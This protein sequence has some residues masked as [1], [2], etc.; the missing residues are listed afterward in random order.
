MAGRVLRYRF[1]A[2]TGRVKDQTVTFEG[3][4]PDNLE[5]DGHNRLWIAS[6]VRNEIVV[7]DLTTGAAQSVF[8]ISTPKSEQ[9]IIEIESRIGEGKS[10]LELLSPPLW[11][12]GPGPIT[13]MV[14][15]PD[16]GPVFATGLG[17]ALIRLKR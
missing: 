10:W 9:A 17:N 5:L 1:D 8:R 14:L 15:S 16:D 6:P 13:G 3:A 4:K 7:L 12:P 11:E 2:Q